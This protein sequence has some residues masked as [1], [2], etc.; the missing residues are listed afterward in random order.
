MVTRLQRI[1]HQ[2]VAVA[3]DRAAQ[4]LQLR[5]QILVRCRDVAEGG[6]AADLRRRVGQRRRRVFGR[7]EQRLFARRQNGFSRHIVDT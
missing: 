1:R 6:Q 7:T 3:L 5:R 4:H 2:P